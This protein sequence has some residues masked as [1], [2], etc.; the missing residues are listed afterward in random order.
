MMEYLDDFIN[1]LVSLFAIAN[2]F[3][4][5]P[6]SLA[7]LATRHRRCVDGSPFVPRWVS[8]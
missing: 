5:V 2:P 7:S 8:F 1:F 4:T 6:V 3:F